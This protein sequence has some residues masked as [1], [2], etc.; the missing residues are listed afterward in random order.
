MIWSTTT[1]VG[2]GC[3]VSP[4]GATYV[5]ARYSPRGNY[6][7]QRPEGAAVPGQALVPSGGALPGQALIPQ[8]QQQKKKKKPK[9]Q[10]NAQQQPPGNKYDQFEYHGQQMP[11]A[12]GNYNYYSGQNVQYPPSTPNPFGLSMQVGPGGSWSPG[13]SPPSSP[14]GNPYSMGPFGPYV[15]PTGRR[16]GHGQST[17]GCTVM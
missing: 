15:P 3:A 11:G 7:G 17:V 5:I 8:Q 14:F 9:A 16:R 13:S 4:S 1:H 2:M 6:V 10:N 12:N